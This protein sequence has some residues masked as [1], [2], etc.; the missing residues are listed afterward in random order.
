MPDSPLPRVERAAI[1]ASN[2]HVFSVARPGRHHDVIRLMVE[3]GANPHGEQ[4]FV[5]T[6]GR[7]VDRAKAAD[8]ALKT[9]QTKALKFNRYE[10]FS[11]DLW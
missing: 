8:I 7:F 6:D 9:G 11:E 2:G 5:L 3:K 4:G 1:K 10:L